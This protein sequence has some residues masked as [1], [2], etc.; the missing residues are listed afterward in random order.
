MLSPDNY[1]QAPDNTQSYN[2]YSYCINNPLKYTDPSGDIFWAPII[3]GAL[4]LTTETGYDIQKYILPVA[5]QVD[6]NF[7]THKSGVGL[8][9]SVGIPQTFIVSAR[10]HGGIAYNWKN[11][12][13]PEGWETNYGAEIGLTPFSVVG[14][15]HYN[16]PGDKFDQTLG[17]LRVGI[18]AFNAKYANDWFFGLPGADNGDR[19]RTATAKIQIGPLDIGFNLFTGDPGRDT[20]RD[21]ETDIIN[22]VRTYIS[23][24]K[25]DNPDEFRAGAGYIGLFG[26]RFGNDSESRR[27]H[28]QNEIVHKNIGSPYF[29]VLDRPNK[30]YFQFGLGGG[31]W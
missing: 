16:S 23:N 7:G 11:Y 31:L 10:V 1:I 27:N 26:F 29:K 2:R 13:I 17:H 28:I 30:W 14:F 25:G 15:T 22:G 21:R 19:Y 20:D 24:R 8:N 3:I 4:L 18:P 12:D 5:V 9:V 6:I